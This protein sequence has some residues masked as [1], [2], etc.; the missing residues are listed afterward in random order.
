[1]QDLLSQSSSFSF[2]RK[3]ITTVEVSRAD[4]QVEGKAPG[5]QASE[6]ALKPVSLVVYHRP[7]YSILTHLGTY[8]VYYE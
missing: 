7:Y 1:M 3:S 8:M 2:V 6:V 5:A 4:P